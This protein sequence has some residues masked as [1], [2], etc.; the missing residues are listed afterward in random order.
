L[1]TVFFLVSIIAVIK[2]KLANILPTCGNNTQ[3]RLVNEQNRLKIKVCMTGV[4]NYKMKCNFN[5]RN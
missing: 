2:T 5:L 3:L 4:N 1:Q